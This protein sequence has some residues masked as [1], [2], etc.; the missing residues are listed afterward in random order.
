MCRKPKGKRG[1]KNVDKE[2]PEITHSKVETPPPKE[3][4]QS[5]KPKVKKVTPK[6]KVTPVPE[7]ETKKIRESS[8]S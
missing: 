4:K 6:T 8:N 7:N 5:S 3:T 2:L 1:K